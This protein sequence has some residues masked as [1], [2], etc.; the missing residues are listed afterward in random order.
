MVPR[1]S[2]KSW[3][4]LPLRETSGSF[5]A[6]LLAAPRLALLFALLILTAPISVAAQADH[7][8]AHMVLVNVT[9]LDHTD[10]A[11]P[12]L[13]AE[14]F[15]V[16][17]NQS[18]QGVTYFSNADEPAS[19]IVVLDT[20]ASM[21]ARIDEERKALAELIHRSNPQDELALI[22]I[23][24]EPQVVVHLG[25][26]SSEIER[27]AGA[28]QADGFGSLWDGMNLGIK[29]LQSSRCRRKTMVVISDDGDKYSRHTPS[30]VM[31]LLKKADVQVYAIGVFDRYANRF[32]VRMRALQLDEVVS[33]TGGR[34]ISSNDFPRAA[35]LISY[36]L[37][38][39]R[40][41]F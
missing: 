35:A 19:L 18:S 28:I 13:E 31:P 3:P 40:R 4:T 24:D 26:S 9:V 32:Q 11:I 36:E 33:A 21:A 14:Q 41:R 17:D 39:Q 22:V 7:N 2:S 23:H 37:R 34:M 38:H 5:A 1:G 25:A 15:A 20:T 30:E 10:R 27:I 6:F 16:L 12:G 29:E 8:E